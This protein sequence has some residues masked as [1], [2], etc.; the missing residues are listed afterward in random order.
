MREMGVVEEIEKVEGKRYQR[1]ASSQVTL[2]F[3]LDTSQ[4]GFW[5]TALK[6]GKERWPDFATILRS[7]ASE[8]Y[9]ILCNVVIAIECH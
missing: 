1:E 4:V 6:S 5:A 7:F 2:G 8:I 3:S 9:T